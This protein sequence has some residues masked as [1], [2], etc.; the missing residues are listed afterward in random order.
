MK[1]KELNYLKKKNNLIKNNILD[2]CYF[3]GGHIMIFL[4]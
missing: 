3:N 1:M 2:V 4:F